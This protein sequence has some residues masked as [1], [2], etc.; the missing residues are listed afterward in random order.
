MNQLERMYLRMEKRKLILKKEAVVKEVEK[1]VNWKAQARLWESI[2]KKAN[3]IAHILEK[4][5]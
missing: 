3:V 1:K 5:L 2:S 4:K